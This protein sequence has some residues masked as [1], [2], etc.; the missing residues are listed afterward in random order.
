MQRHTPP[1]H[2]HLRRLALW[3]YIRTSR[4]SRSRARPIKPNVNNIYSLATSPSPH[5]TKWHVRQLFLGKK[6]SGH[7]TVCPSGALC[8]SM[9]LP[10]D[11]RAATLKD[12]WAL[13]T[14]EDKHD[15]SSDWTKR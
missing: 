8:Y 13:P 10:G 12:T 4:L 14:T 1:W 5:K 3:T 6:V 11:G 15:L 9:L 7:P 2:K